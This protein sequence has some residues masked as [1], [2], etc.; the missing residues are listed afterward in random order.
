MKKFFTLVSIT[1]LLVGCSYANDYNTEVENYN[2]F[3]K[4]EFADKINS[5]DVEA[6]ATL[7]EEFRL[8]D[9][10]VKKTEDKITDDRRIT[11]EEYNEYK[12]LLDK[13]YKFVN[14]Y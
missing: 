13:V 2:S 11:E 8:K 1:F 10:E 4:N 5:L 6:A 9:A 12:N 7:R 14:E 3:V